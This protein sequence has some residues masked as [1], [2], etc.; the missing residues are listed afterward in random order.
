VQQYQE[1]GVAGFAQ[2]YTQDFNAVEAPAYAVQV[3]VRRW[4]REGAKR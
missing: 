4:V 2:R 1:W 3:E